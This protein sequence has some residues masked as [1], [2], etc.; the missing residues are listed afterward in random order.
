MEA[1]FFWVLLFY[2]KGLLVFQD[3][4]KC[5]GSGIVERCLVEFE[6]YTV[7]SFVEDGD[8]VEESWVENVFDYFP[9]L[10]TV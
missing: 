5:M 6:R 10:H 4:G 7:D 3:E 9:V 8:W 1:R 2:E